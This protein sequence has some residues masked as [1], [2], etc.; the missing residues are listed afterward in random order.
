MSIVVNT[1]NGNI[2][3]PL[4]EKLLEAGKQVTL[5]SRSPGKVADLVKRG[6]RLVEGSID[7]SAVVASALKGAEALFWLTPAAFRPDFIEWAQENARVAAQAVRANGVGRVVVLSSMGAQNGPG[8]GPVGALLGVE[9]AFKAATPNVTILRPGFFMENL[10]RDLDALAKAGSIFMPVP[11]EKRV[12]MVAT[13]DIAAKAAEVLLDAGW[14]GHRYLGVH[15]PVD[16]SYGEAAAILSEALGR[17]VRYVQVTLDDVRKALLDA[18]MPGFAVDLFVEMYK[19]IPEGRLDAA[20]P[21]SKETTTP[22]TLAH[23]ARTVLKPAVES[24]A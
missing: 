23:F 15:G 17:P 14:K 2:G 10:L 19:A 20:E 22:T 3:R 7:D 11:P 24:V 13:A 1:P 9:E 12:P 16:I 21:R 8:T 18:G 4:V 5:I 6:A